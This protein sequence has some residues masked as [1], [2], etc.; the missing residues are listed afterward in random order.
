MIPTTVTVDIDKHAI[1]EVVKQ[2]IEK[3]TIEALW[4]VDVDKLSRLTTMS[5]RFLEDE[6]LCDPRMRM[7]EVKK[8]RKRWYPAK[9]SKEVIFEILSEW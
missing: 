6:I 4:L 9:K 7:I 1:R 5:K 2:F 8:S 3:E